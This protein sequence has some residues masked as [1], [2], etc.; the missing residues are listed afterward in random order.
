MEQELANMMRIL[1]HAKNLPDGG[2]K[3]LSK[4]ADMR[5]QIQQQTQ[6]IGQLQ[7]D[8]SLSVK[9]EIAKSFEKSLEVV[10]V[11]Q[12]VP[13]IPIIE[14][15]DN[16]YLKAVD[17]QPK[18]T[19]KVGMKNFETKKALTVE[20]LQEFADSLQ[21][22]PTEDQLDEPPKYLKC[23][24]MRHQLHALK[25]MRW[26]ETQKVKGG[27]LADD[28]GLGKT[29]TTI[30]LIMKQLQ[31]D[32]EKE[33]ES[34]EGEDSDDEEEEKSGWMA[35][36]RRER[37]VRGGTLVI[38]PASLLKQWEMEIDQ[39]SEARC[40]RCDTFP[41]SEAN[42]QGKRAREVRRGD[43]IVSDDRI[44]TQERGHRV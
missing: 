2:Q 33:D 26:R 16:D 43:H 32:E 8:E 13:M 30:S 40:T 19:G 14:L 42:L 17:V 20:T 3:L 12:N 4:V 41:R 27:I 25:F 21:A 31:Y 36:G 44:R 39:K 28:M 29:L 7:I 10:E 34:E 35:R 23:T 22:R 38:A 6:H 18:Y 1:D 9:N 37:R 15:N 11:A 24:L 5:K